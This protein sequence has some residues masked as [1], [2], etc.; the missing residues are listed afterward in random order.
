M[1]RTAATALSVAATAALVAT[2]LAALPGSAAAAATPAK[3]A[4][5]TLHFA[6][7]TG[8]DGSQKC[9]IIGDLY[10]PKS[11]SPEHRVPAILTTNGFGGSKD[12]QAGLGKAFASRGYEVLS[13][14]GLGFGGSGCKITLDD[15]DYDGKAGSQLVSFLG[16]AKGIAYTDAAHTTPVKALRVVELDKRDHAGK[17]RA[18]DPRLGMI[19]GSYGGGNQFAVASVDPRVDTIVPFITWNDLTYSLAP[20][21]TDQTTGVTTSNP[22][23]IKLTWG[24][25]FSADGAADGVQGGQGD[26]TRLLGCPNFAT[27]VCP[28]LVTGGSTGYFQDDALKAFRHASVA[29]Y[30]HKIKIPVLLIQG[31]N[32]TLFNLNE[33]TAT[34]KALRAQH[35]PVK[36]IWQSW[37]HSQSTPA[38]GELDLSNPN[39]KTQYETKRVAAWFDHY[40]RG[41]KHANTGP[42]FS[43]FRNWVTYHGI[44]TPAYRNMSHFPVGTMRKLYLSGDGTLVKSATAV[45]AG[46]QNFTTPPAGAPTTVDP[47]DVIGSFSDQIPNDNESD[48]PGTFASWTSAALPKAQ[49]VVG[50]PKLHVTLSAPTAAGSQAAG[51]AGQLVLF[52]KVL[53]VGKDG[54]AHLIKGLVAPIRIADASKPVT[55][56]LPGI[57]HRFNKGHEIRIVIAGA[58]PNYRGGLTP[59]PVTIAGG[60][61]QV[62]SLPVS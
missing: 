8:P 38:P 10:T 2:S 62:L 59:T 9:D 40:L 50:S 28:A 42:R 52:A 27:F 14:S 13:Y 20:N 57:V 11:A 51:P 60:K 39:P 46:S 15:P 23:T 24:L 49:H 58:S 36:M 47:V 26:P 56:T 4:V 45:K 43:Y 32:D 18:H 37:G 16:G 3:Y 55:V 5:R 12:D 54:K 22:G 48:A 31:E 7:D 19:G 33:A 25:L 53:D 6:V 41:N 29:H 21:N 44:A 61:G 30:L 34:F 35:T 1:R 17:H